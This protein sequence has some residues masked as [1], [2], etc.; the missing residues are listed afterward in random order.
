VVGLLANAAMDGKG[1]MVAMGIDLYDAL[2][3]E[4]HPNLV[5]V[6]T[7]PD[8]RQFTTTPQRALRARY[9]SFVVFA[10]NALDD[11]PLSIR[12][13]HR[14]E[15]GGELEVGT[16]TLKMSDLVAGG[17]VGLKNGSIVDLKLVADRSS[18]ADGAV[19]G[20][21][22]LQAQGQVQ[23]AAQQVRPPPPPPRK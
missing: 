5:A 19:H 2:P 3:H 8:G 22:P 6:M 15:M 13:V 20:F 21:A 14:D 16:V 23:P 4:N 11:R 1:N 18:Q 9:E 12:V 10:T 7:L 17:E